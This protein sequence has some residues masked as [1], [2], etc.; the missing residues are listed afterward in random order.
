MAQTV[1]EWLSL[2]HRV[3]ALETHLLIDMICV[4][5]PRNRIESSEINPYLYGQL[6][7]DKGGRNIKWSKN[8]LINKW[9]WEI[10]TTTC[11][12]MKH[13]H[14]LTPY[15][16]I[17]S[18]WIKDLFSVLTWFYW[19]GFCKEITALRAVNVRMQCMVDG[20]LSWKHIGLYLVTGFSWT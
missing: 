13:D 6:I 8:S 10:W 20:G 14:Q 2:W 12:K 7:F 15:T 5:D 16:T 11:K 4:I 9:C 3:T 1:T 17:N 18:R 19:F